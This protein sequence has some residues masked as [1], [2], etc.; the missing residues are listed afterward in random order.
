MFEDTI[1]MMEDLVSRGELVHANWPAGECLARL[2]EARELME[3]IA[4]EN[5]RAAE[6]SCRFCG[7]PFHPATG[8][9]YTATFVACGPCT[10]SFW[11]WFRPF[12]SSKGRRRGPAFYDHVIFTQER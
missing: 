8:C 9:A 1:A 4:G 6:V 7:G 10:R 12:M 5:E 3:R 11:A 2:R